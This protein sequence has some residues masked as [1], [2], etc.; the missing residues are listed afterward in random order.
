MCMRECAG[1][2]MALYARLCV[3]VSVNSFELVLHL[4][5]FLLTLVFEVPA[6]RF[7]LLLFNVFNFSFICVFSCI[8]NA[9]HLRCAQIKKNFLFNLESV[10]MWSLC[11]FAWCVCVCVLVSLRWFFPLK[12]R[13]SRL[14][15][16]CT[17]HSFAMNKFHF[18]ELEWCSNANWFVLNTRSFFRESH[19]EHLKVDWFL[20]EIR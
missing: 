15:C 19:Q 20:M 12:N 17:Q 5:F 13:I 6:L 1:R 2:S 8:S 9:L 16:E 10:W 7:L 3:C 14:L 18:L 11:F 4:S